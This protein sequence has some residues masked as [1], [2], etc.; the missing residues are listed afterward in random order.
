MSQHY[1]CWSGA[2]LILW[3]MT[4]DQPFLYCIERFHWRFRSIVLVKCHKLHAFD[5]TTCTCHNTICW[6]RSCTCVCCMPTSLC[7]IYM[8]D[9]TVRPFAQWQDCVH[10]VAEGHNS[11]VVIGLTYHLLGVLDG[12]SRNSTVSL[13]K[14]TYKVVVRLRVYWVI[15]RALLPREQVFEHKVAPCIIVLVKNGFTFCL[16]GMHRKQ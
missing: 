7:C 8:A 5:C 15:L 9:W 2:T 12:A 14:C 11:C 1:V 13:V 6:C 10:M 16:H 4:S 3:V